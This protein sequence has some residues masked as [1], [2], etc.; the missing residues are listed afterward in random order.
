MH[1]GHMP[2]FAFL[3]T[4]ADHDAIFDTCTNASYSS[5][6]SMIS[7]RCSRA[8]GNSCAS[9]SVTLLSAKAVLGIGVSSTYFTTSVS[10]STKS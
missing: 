6:S 5:S 2:N 8:L 10:V 1:H 9:L 3:L 7:S 4:D